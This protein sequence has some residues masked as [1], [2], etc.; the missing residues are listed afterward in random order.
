VRP[1]SWRQNVTPPPFPHLPRERPLRHGVVWPA[2]AAWHGW[3]PSPTVA[4]PSAREFLQTDGA[5]LLFLDPSACWFTPLSLHLP[6]PLSWYAWM[7]AW[8]RPIWYSPFFS[9][10]S[11][12]LL[13]ILLFFRSWSARFWWISQQTTIMPEMW[14]HEHESDICLTPC[15]ANVFRFIICISIMCSDEYDFLLLLHLKLRES[16]I[17]MMIAP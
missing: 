12:W 10:P 6:L 8:F 1:V 14:A 16:A 7:H 3:P 15:A 17:A 2:H 5:A 9:Y 4:T 11:T 13:W